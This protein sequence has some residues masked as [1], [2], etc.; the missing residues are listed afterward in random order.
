MT[1]YRSGTFM[2]NLW[3]I[4]KV[5]SI[6]V[7]VVSQATDAWDITAYRNN[8]EV[9]F[10]NCAEFINRISE[11]NKTQADNV[12]TLDIVIPMVHLIECSDNRSKK[13]DS[14][15]QHCKYDN[16]AKSESFTITITIAINNG[17]A[18]VEITA[19]LKYLSNF[20][21]LLKLLE[22]SWS[23]LVWRLGYLWRT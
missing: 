1:N 18:N 22:K 2:L 10:K 9:I 15:G 12:K 8:K 17:S 21:E 13:S 6:R 5:V 4:K 23:N 20:G 19:P 16:I 7:T 14:L 3:Q 11:I